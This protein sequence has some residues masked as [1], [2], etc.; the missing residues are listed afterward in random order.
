MQFHEHI[1]NIVVLSRKFCADLTLLERYTI[2]VRSIEHVERLKHMEERGLL[3]RPLPAVA[4]VLDAAVVSVRFW[5]NDALAW[6][7]GAR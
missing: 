7:N 1:A 6:S 3:Q 4:L 2:V 5:S